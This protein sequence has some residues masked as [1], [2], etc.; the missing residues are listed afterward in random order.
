[1]V[2]TNY[3]ILIVDQFT[4]KK[5]NRFVK[6]KS[7][8]GEKIAEVVQEITRDGYKVKRIRCDNAGEK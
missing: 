2:G 3:W 1:M 6:H 8:M 4:R 5:W 7:Q